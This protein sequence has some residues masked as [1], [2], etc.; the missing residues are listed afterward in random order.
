M[1]AVRDVK[2]VELVEKIALCFKD[3]GATPAQIAEEKARLSKDDPYLE[4]WVQ[5]I[6]LTKVRKKSFTATLR[7]RFR[8]LFA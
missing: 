6:D 4:G 1:H 2:R 8:S 7:D 5:T 3:M